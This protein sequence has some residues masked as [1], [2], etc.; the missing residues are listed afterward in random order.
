MHGGISHQE[1]KTTLR[2]QKCPFRFVLPF[3]RSG[4][5]LG[6]LP[7]QE[8]LYEL[9]R[10][11]CQGTPGAPRLRLCTST[12]ALKDEKKLLAEIQSLKR[13]R[14][15]VNQVAQMESQLSSFD[16]GLSLKDQKQAINE[17]M[18]QY[19]EAKKKVSEKM[20]ELTNQRKDQVGDVDGVREQREEVNKLIQGTMF[21][22]AFA[23]PGSSWPSWLL[24][25]FLAP[26][27]PPGSSWLPL[28]PPG[29]PGSS[30][31]PLAP[32]GPPGSSWLL[33]APP[34]PPG[35]S[36]PSWLLLALQ[37]GTSGPPGS[38]WPGFFLS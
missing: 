23:P 18:A 5:T 29:P 31:L 25:A 12:M 32:S 7:I 8:M 24:L 4:I 27:G 38:S 13:N 37:N 26:P 11:S 15:K 33:L 6:A 34:G 36:W 19:R 35:S 17:E 20:T 14:P 21:F 10:C 3:P 2:Y 30:W 9:Y 1:R 22:R 16:P 28:A